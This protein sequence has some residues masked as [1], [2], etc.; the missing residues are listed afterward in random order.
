MG[1]VHKT[2]DKKESITPQQVLY[3]LACPGWSQNRIAKT[4]AI[5]KKTVSSITHGEYEKKKKRR[6]PKFNTEH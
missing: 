5:S 4:F 1:V 3:F 2:A 6:K